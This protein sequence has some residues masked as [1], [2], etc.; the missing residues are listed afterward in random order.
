MRWYEQ[1]AA[2]RMSPAQ[3][4]ASIQSGQRVYVH[5]GAAIPES[6][7]RAMTDRAAELR[8]V[9][10]VHLLHLGDAPYM[11]PGLEKHFR[12]NAFFVGKNTR[13]AVNSGRADFTPVF[14]SE[15]PALFASGQMPIDVALLQVSPPDEHGFVSLGVSTD[16]TMAAGRAANTIIA[17]VNEQM[18]RVHGDNFVHVSRLNTIVEVSRPLPEL[19]RLRMSN[20]Q[21]TIGHRVAELIVDGATL[22]MGIGGI[23]DAVLHFLKDKNDLGVHSEMFSDGII[24]LAEEGIITGR[25]KTLHPRKIVASFMFGSKAVY[26]FVHD[27]PLIELHPTEYVNDPFIISQNDNMVSI[28]SAIQIDLTGQVAADSM[29]YH[30]Y[31]GIGGQVDFLRGA[32]RAKNGKPILALPST[33]LEGKVSRIVS[34]LD[35]G[36]GVVTS[37]GDVHWVVTE[38]GAVNLHGTPLRRRAEMLLSVAHPDF[39]RELAADARRRRSLDLK[40]DASAESSAEKAV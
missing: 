18:P 28:N 3:A 37:R 1:F 39:R 6:L 31:S 32:A 20:E 25:H 10:V 24:E 9:E 38:Y 8:D 30:I 26:D 33:A 34:A 14:L 12:H 22:Q 36:A 13:D 15:I 17:E 29:G 4:V 19:P 40:W 21:R 7:V 23:P 27:N 11:A 16:I 2:K 5:P 35:E